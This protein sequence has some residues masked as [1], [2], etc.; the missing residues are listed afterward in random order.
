M[1]AVVA[2]TF[3]EML[4]RMEEFDTRSAERWER[5]EKKG[6]E[7][8]SAALQEREEAVDGRLAA[9]E[10]FAS[11]QYTAAVVADNWGT[12]F[13]SR[14]TDLEQRMVD[15]ELIRLAEIRDEQD[16][17]V[18]ALEG[19]VGELQSWRPEIDGHLDDIHYE[20]RRLTKS[21]AMQ[22]QQPPLKARQESAA[23]AQHPSRSLVD[24]PNGHRVV[25]TTRAPKYGSVAT[26]IPTPA[27]ADWSTLCALVRECFCRDQH[28]LLLRQL[29]NIR[30]TCSVQEYVDKFVDLIEQLS[31]YTP[32]PNTLSYTTR[33]IDGLHDDIRSVVLVQHPGDLDTACTLALLK[34]EAI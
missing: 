1:D 28:E 7:D 19:A 2:K 4:K 18:E 11:S 23:A 34:E 26:I 5:L 25:M 15:I 6:F 24:W 12:H 3:D 10:D 16:D 30:Q 33:F 27:N 31:A 20:H 29:F 14:V 32:Y 17:R 22:P 21:P 8:A 9:L 13:D